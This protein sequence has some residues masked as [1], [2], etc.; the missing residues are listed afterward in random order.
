MVRRHRGPS[1][2]AVTQG[3][4]EGGGGGA[5]TAFCPGRHRL[6]LRDCSYRFHFPTTYLGGNN[7]KTWLKLEIQF[8]AVLMIIHGLVRGCNDITVIRQS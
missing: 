1:L 5:K 7:I 8:F 2:Y 4:G 3:D 6:T